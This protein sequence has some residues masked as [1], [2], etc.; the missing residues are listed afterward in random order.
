[1]L[2]HLEKSIVD[3]NNLPQVTRHTFD[4]VIYDVLGELLE[5]V[6]FERSWDFLVIVTDA[7]QLFV[8]LRRGVLSAAYQNNDLLKGLVIHAKLLANLALKHQKVCYCAPLLL[9][10]GDCLLLGLF[11]ALG[12]L[13]NGCCWLVRKSLK[14]E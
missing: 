6:L 7:N 14:L 9:L 2:R 5:V 10:K 1:M 4:F 12:G 8:C 13:V 3:F 11:L